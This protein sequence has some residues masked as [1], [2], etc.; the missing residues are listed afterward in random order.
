MFRLCIIMGTLEHLGERFTVLT[1]V[2]VCDTVW[3]CWMENDIWQ[4]LWMKPF[5]WTSN[6]L[7]LKWSHL[8]ASE[9]L[10]Y[11]SLNLLWC[12]FCPFVWA[13]LDQ[14]CLT[15]SRSGKKGLYRTVTDTEYQ[16][17]ASLVVC[18]LGY[19]AQDLSVISC[20]K[21]F[22][23]KSTFYICL[24]GACDDRESFPTHLSGSWS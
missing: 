1:V 9:H 18:T 24:D 13:W 5:L 2:N 17:G 22:W 4:L 15:V 11:N 10:E 16:I 7:F 23:P 6:Y 14:S 12:F 3:R 21:L 20:V 19:L 8:M